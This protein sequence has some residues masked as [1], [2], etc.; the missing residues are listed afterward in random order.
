MPEKKK[1]P[2]GIDNFEKIIKNNFYYVDK[3][4]ILEKVVIL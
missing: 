4:E 1:L 2:V 3:T